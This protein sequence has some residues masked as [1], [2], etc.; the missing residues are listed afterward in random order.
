[1]RTLAA[2]TTRPLHGQAGRLGR[3]IVHGLRQVAD[4]PPSPFIAQNDSPA[5]DATPT[6]PTAD[7]RCYRQRSGGRYLA[8][9]LLAHFAS[10]ASHGREACHLATA[11]QKTMSVK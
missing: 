5:S 2:S 11:G 8:Y 7:S 4:S 10:H 3:R 1:M 9:L 6:M